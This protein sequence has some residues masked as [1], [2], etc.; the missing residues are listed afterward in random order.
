M[1]IN[2]NFRKIFEM[3]RSRK[4]QHFD[5]KEEEEHHNYLVENN[6]LCIICFSEISENEAKLSCT[7]NFHKECINKWFRIKKVCPVCNHEHP[8]IKF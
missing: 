2:I 4:V 3:C 7:H 8:N 5:E 6:K 1:N